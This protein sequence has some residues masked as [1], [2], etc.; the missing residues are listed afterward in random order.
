[1]EELLITVFAVIAVLFAAS[2]VVL[3]LRIGKLKTAL[4][5]SRDYSLEQM[6]LLSKKDREIETEKEFVRKL[7]DAL[8]QSKA[9]VNELKTDNDEPCGYS[10]KDIKETC[11]YGVS[12]S[13]M[14]GKKALIK[15]FS[16]DDI[17]YNYRLAHELKEQLEEEL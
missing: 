5:E 4:R 2:S 17:D 6:E 10:V 3:W 15:V 12:A 14:S 7:D 13:Y 16:T 9:A 1:M 8:S 11:Y